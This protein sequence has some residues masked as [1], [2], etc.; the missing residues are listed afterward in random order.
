MV[1]TTT[2]SSALR[3][4]ICRAQATALPRRLAMEPL[5]STHLAQP[6]SFST[7]PISM[8]LKTRYTPEHEWVT[9][10]PES[11]IGTVG[12]TDYAQK[13]LGDVVFVELPTEGTDVAKGGEFG[14]DLLP[15]RSNLADRILVSFQSKSEP[16][17]LSRQLLISTPP[18]P[19]VSSRSTRGC[20]TSPTYSTRAPK[21]MVSLQRCG[22]RAGSRAIASNQTCPDGLSPDRMALSNSPLEPRGIRDIARGASVQEAYRRGGTLGQSRLE[23]I[24]S[25]CHL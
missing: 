23:L 24:I 5:R 2:A 15:D 11:N 12:I 7:T 9:L 4:T 17:N 16:S 22:S 1:L 25:A 3:S 19:E 8:A 14:M 20:P 6:R 18:S 21:R 13:S 10:D